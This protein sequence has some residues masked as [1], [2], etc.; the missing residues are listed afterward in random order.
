MNRVF[1]GSTAFTR[2]NGE[3][4]KIYAWKVIPLVVFTGL[5]LSLGGYGTFVKGYNNLWLVAGILPGLSYMALAASRQPA[6]QIENAYRYI[7]AKRVATCELEANA[8]R[9][10]ENAFTQTD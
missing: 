9:L 4:A 3:P 8:G 6:V 2:A 10:T 1:G 7:L 5:G